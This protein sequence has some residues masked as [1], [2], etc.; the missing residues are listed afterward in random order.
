VAQWIDRLSTRRANLAAS[1]SMVKSCR[2]LEFRPS[3]FQESFH[4]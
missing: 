3:A 4:S 2:G 1:V